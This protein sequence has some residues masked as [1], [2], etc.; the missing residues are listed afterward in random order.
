MIYNSV[1]FHS[2][3]NLWFEYSKIFYLHLPW[4]IIGNFNF[5]LSRSEHKGGSYAY[6]D[7]KARLFLDFV[8]NNNL[9]DLNFS[10]PQFTW[11][12]N[13][14]GRPHL[15]AKLDRCLVNFEWTNVFNSYNLKHLSHSFFDHSH[16]LL[17]ISMHPLNKHSVFQFEN[18]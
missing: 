12:N 14:Y 10:S 9:F 7:R 8:E 5:V 16:L 11:C 2:Q 6:Y 15:W 17:S 18:F 13:H 1:C 4:L 3:C